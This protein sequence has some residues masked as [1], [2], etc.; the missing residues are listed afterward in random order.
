MTRPALKAAYQ[1]PGVVTFKSPAPVGVE[2]RVD[3]VLA[4]LSGLSL[5]SQRDIPMTLQRIAELPAP[6]R[7]HVIE[8]DLFR[9]DEAPP[10]HKEGELASRT[11]AALREAAPGAFHESP[12]AS[13]GDLVLDVVVAPDEPI[14]L[15]A[16]RHTKDRSPHA[17]GRYVYD[18][19]PEAP[20]RAFRKTEEAV[21]AFEL[22]LAA[23]DTAVELGA[24]PGGGSL[25]LLRRGV[26]VVAV[27]PA[28]MDARI[29]AFVGP[30]GARLTHLKHT[31]QKV[32]R[33]HLPPS[34][35]WLLMDVNLAPQVALRAAAHVASLC[36]SSLL[37][38]ILTLKLNDWAFLDQLPR[39]LDQAREMGLVEPRARQLPAHRQE[40]VL[41]GLTA[42][43]QARAVP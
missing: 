32:E 43:G 10:A 8:R 21:L 2:D 22:P 19:P 37:G 33:A 26:N 3:A 34:V 28:E 29:A 5:G 42:R 9:P 1:R 25:A 36:R 7:L 6:L 13:V 30:S 27:D 14:L 16:H 39:F 18:V 20:S 11:E 38:A 15:G 35:Q 24:A 40:I 12:V 4:R 17:G 23:G 31:M 41:V